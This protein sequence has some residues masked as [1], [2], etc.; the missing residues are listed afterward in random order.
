MKE[1]VL[2]SADEF[3]LLQEQFEHQDLS[4]GSEHPRVTLECPSLV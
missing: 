3:M 4:Y 1:H 2:L